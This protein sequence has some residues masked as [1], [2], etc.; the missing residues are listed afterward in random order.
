MSTLLR[1]AAVPDAAA[2]AEVHVQSWQDTYA[3]LMPESF[4]ARMTGEEMRLRR[5]ANWR[6]TIQ[7]SADVVWVAEQGGQIVAFASAGAPR[8]HP[9][10]DA[11][12]FTLYALRR[13][14]GQ[15]LG[16]ALLRATVRALTDRG[17]RNLALWVLDVN[18]TRQWYR[19]QGAREAGTK[20][21]PVAGGELREV[22]MV[23]DELP[24][25]E[26]AREE[27]AP[28]QPPAG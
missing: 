3:G 19:R 14:Q 23:W 11:E 17:A 18:P 27:L 12:L 20:V 16:G 13:V 26:P 25:A 22:R 21:E 9:G 1:P 4:L 8:D 24:W 15:G 10:Y 7:Q 28:P 6:Q 2:I 5:E